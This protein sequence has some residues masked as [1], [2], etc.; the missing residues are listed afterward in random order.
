MHEFKITIDSEAKYLEGFGLSLHNIM[1]LPLT[2]RSLNKKGLR[3]EDGRVIDY[4][5]TGLIL[6]Q[7]L[8]ENKLIRT[9]PKNGAYRGKSV[10]VA[11][12]RDKE[13]DVI[14]AIGISDAYGA[15]DFIECFCRNP[16]EIS[17][18]KKCITNKKTN[19]KP[20]KVYRV[21]GIR[22]TGVVFAETPE[23]A[24]SKAF[25]EGSVGDWEMPQAIEVPLPKDYKI[26]RVD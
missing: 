23:K 26:I 21:E 12:I 4:N 5:Y 24:I 22:H 25:E 10:L 6:E 17:E 8:K 19:D 9:I 3:I 11:P 13:G 15:I 2:L 20:I 16:T 14:A 18:I 7:V 1:K